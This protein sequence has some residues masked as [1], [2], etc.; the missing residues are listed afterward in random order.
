MNAFKRIEHNLEC[1]K[2]VFE[3]YVKAIDPSISKWLQYVGYEINGSN[4][5]FKFKSSQCSLRFETY[6]GVYF[7]W[8]DELLLGQFN[9]IYNYFRSLKYKTLNL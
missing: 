2:P 4:L 9:E 1:A 6:A 3:R 8:H 5:V 7:E